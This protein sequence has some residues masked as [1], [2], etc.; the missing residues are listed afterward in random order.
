MTQEAE[1]RNAFQDQARW[2]AAL[3]SPF[4]A[5]LMQAM[6][7][8]LNRRS[9][10]GRR[11]LGWDGRADALGDAVPLRLAGALNHLVRKGRLA[12]LARLY[13]PNQLPS[14]AALGKAVLSALDTA[15]DEICDWLQYPPQTNE[16]A[17]SAM[18]YA[19]LKTVAAETG[20]PLSL[21]ELAGSAGL[22]LIP[23]FYQYRFGG[24]AAGR[25]G[26]SVSMA[27]DWSG[28]PPPTAEPCIKSRQ[29]CDQNPLNVSDSVHMDR[30]FSYIWP[31][32]PE[33]LSRVQAAVEIARANNGIIEKA[34]A[35]DWVEREMSVSAG[36]GI[37]RVLYHSISYQYFPD[38]IQNRISAR[39]AAA[40]RQARDD[41]PLAWLAFEQYQDQ[42]PCLTLRL[43]P[44][45]AIR[46][47]AKGDAHARE[48]N[49]LG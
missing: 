21:Y 37:A 16:V 5:R 31:D 1:I 8:C 4:T 33:R 14:L 28:N 45:G 32:Q 23:D 48:I 47:L 35:A 40:G 34:D 26:S 27:P 18:L 29:G 19:G 10:A 20:L 22:N 25:A 15:D 24:V 12:E 6:A 13:P 17:R 46:I 43:W 36:A 38:E 11:I 49:W 44:G 42:G 41:A 30:L 3:G 7:E 2:C 39:M 9:E